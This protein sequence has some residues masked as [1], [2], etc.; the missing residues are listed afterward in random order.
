MGDD[1][2]AK[3]G[4]RITSSFWFVEE[5]S[6]DLICK[7]KL[8]GIT[9][10]TQ[11]EFQLVQVVETKPFGKTLVLDGKTQ[12]A[13]M[14]EFIYHESL[15]HPAMLLHPCPK[16]VYVG[17]GGEL[18]TAREILRHR[19]VEKCIMVD[20]DK[21]VVDVSRTQLPEWGCGCT[22]DD[23][24]VVHYSDAY[25]WLQDNE[26]KFDVII[27]DIADPIEAGPGYIL[28]TEEF[29]KFARSRLLPGGIIVT[30]SGPGSIHNHT[31]CFTVINK[32]LEKAFPTVIPYTVDIPSF[33][34]SW[35]F[36]MG[37][38][39]P[40]KGQQEI[41]QQPVKVTDKLIDERIKGELC[42][43]DGIAWPGLFSLAKWLRKTIKAEERIFTKDNP[44]F[45][46]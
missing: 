6:Q 46:W 8:M 32:T 20:L 7:M 44:C 28:Y 22:E 25:A 33:G 4:P 1:A 26:E 23:R 45:M 27:M 5:I 10:D 38:L 12:S 36:N 2:D 39:E 35:G 11:S 19:S 41:M 3:E 13:Q 17:G 14:D 37:F 24:L 16:K 29:Y 18:A 31:D 34:S 15:V 40:S 43:L 42:F 30:Q 9:H 21:V